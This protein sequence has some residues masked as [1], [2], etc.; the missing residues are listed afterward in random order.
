MIEN[1]VTLTQSTQ[2]PVTIDSPNRDPLVRR[3]F[4][5]VAS[6]YDLMNDLMS[7][8]I[9]RLWKD[10]MVTAIAPMPNHSILDVAGGTG[11]I[12]FRILERQPL[13]RV[14]S[15]DINEKML[16]VGRDRA[17]DRGYYDRIS[18]IVASA[19]SLPIAASSL[20]AYSIA[21]GLRNVSNRAAAL[22]EAYR[23]LQP[24]GKFLCLEFSHLENPL[25]KN[26][27]QG[28]SRLLPEIGAII[29]KDR[30]AY[31]YLVESIRRFPL[32]PELAAEMTAAGFAMVKWR[33]LSAGIVALHSG[34]KL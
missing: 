18:H 17:I 13:A 11:D 24:G 8:G 31:S 10:I 15:L 3:V 1:S 16:A 4:D 6:R 20:N 34:V 12:G 19:E 14:L 9:H 28:W 25:L 27:Y 21:F 22:Q 30:D 29:A 32:Q 23:V 26:A 7:L 33:N 2:D 5:S